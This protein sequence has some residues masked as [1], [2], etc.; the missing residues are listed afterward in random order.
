MGQRISGAFL[1]HVLVAFVAVGVASWLGPALGHWEALLYDRFIALRPSHEPLV[2]MVVVERDDARRPALGCESPYDDGKLIPRAIAMA[3]KGRANAIVLGE[4]T[5]EFV[6]GLD[7]RG[8]R[9]DA[10]ASYGPMVLQVDDYPGRP[11]SSRDGG[12]PLRSL[13]LWWDGES[14]HGEPVRLASL[15][16][17]KRDDEPGREPRRGAPASQGLLDS[18]RDH[19]ALATLRPI[20]T[21]PLWSSQPLQAMNWYGPRGSFRRFTLGELAEGRVPADILDGAVVVIGSG[22]FVR[23]TPV[24]PMSRAEVYANLAA[25]ALEDSWIRPLPAWWHWLVMFVAVAVT[26][27]AI[28]CS[29]GWIGLITLLFMSA[30]IGMVARGALVRDLWFC[31]TPALASLALGVVGALAVSVGVER[32]ERRALSREIRI[33]AQVVSGIVHDLRN[34]LAVA[35]LAAEAVARRGDAQGAAATAKEAVGRLRRALR[36]LDRGISNVLDANP[37]R[38]LRPALRPTSL[39]DLVEEVV[40]DVEAVGSGHDIAV[41]GEQVETHAD[42]ELL[43]RALVNLLENAVKYSPA[44]G[45]IKVKVWQRGDEVGIDVTDV[46]IGIHQRDVARLCEPFY[47]VPGIDKIAKGTGLGLSVVKRIAAAHGGRLEIQSE[48]GV[49]STFVIVL[50]QRQPEESVETEGLR[51]RPPAWT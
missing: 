38:Q 43:H 47:R 30:V 15:R 7:R 21:L 17:F 44:G 51:Q 11:A 28:G 48:P 18:G 20:P 37:H 1:L 2:R 35:T 13:I 41:E 10:A 23:Q 39:R 45:A 16:A 9:R 12:R 40:D 3:E 19:I 25:T 33:R 8:W 34:P 6:A 29:S 32:Y 27:A 31:C 26:V 49:G 46:G 24:G 50:P 5:M 14:G 4:G 36:Q 42:P 22:R